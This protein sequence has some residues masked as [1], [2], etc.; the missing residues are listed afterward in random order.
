MFYINIYWV[1]IWDQPLREVLCVDEFIY[2]HEAVGSGLLLY[3]RDV[4][5]RFATETLQLCPGPSGDTFTPSSPVVP[6]VTPV[7]QLL[8][9][10]S[11]DLLHIAR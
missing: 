5:D 11:S 8:E 10:W 1:F 7:P 9:N 6:H 2:P 4:G 3:G